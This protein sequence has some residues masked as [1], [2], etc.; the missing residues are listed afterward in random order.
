MTRTAWHIFSHELHK[1]S[2]SRTVSFS[3]LCI[4][5]LYGAIQMLLLLLLLLLLN[6]KHDIGVYKSL[7]V[8]KLQTKLRVDA[9]W[10]VC[11]V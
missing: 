10:L 3:H 9:A 1:N 11:N 6:R 2:S 5:G 8:N 4:F 7:E